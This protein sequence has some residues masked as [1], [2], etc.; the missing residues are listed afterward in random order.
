MIVS[1][2]TNAGSSAVRDPH[3]QIAIPIPIDDCHSAG[4]IFEIDAEATPRRRQSRCP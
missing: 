2:E 3:V 4:I 1:Q